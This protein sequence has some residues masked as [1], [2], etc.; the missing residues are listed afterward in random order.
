MKRIIAT[1]LGILC[2]TAAFAGTAVITTSADSASYELTVTTVPHAE[3]ANAFVCSAVLKDRATDEVLAAPKVI[4]K[5]G[6]PARLEIQRERRTLR[7]DIL[8]DAT[9]NE[10]KAVVEYSL[11]G[12]VVFAPTV[13]FELR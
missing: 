6:E 5:A 13:I 2:A 11:D 9:K 8:S 12:T 3:T 4:F 10:A 7:L 1:L